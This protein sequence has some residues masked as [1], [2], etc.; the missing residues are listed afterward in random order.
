MPEQPIQYYNFPR[1]IMENL[2][3]MIAE[4]P[5]MNRQQMAN[6]YYENLRDRVGIV[7]FTPIPAADEPERVTYIRNL[8]RFGS[9]DDSSVRLRI[10]TF[11]AF[12]QWSAIE[13]FRT[14]TVR[15]ILTFPNIQFFYTKELKRY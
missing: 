14:I 6:S 7:G 13:R 2:A 15:N 11:E 1:F 9:F 8:N 3:V 10:L 4:W 12:R 5:N